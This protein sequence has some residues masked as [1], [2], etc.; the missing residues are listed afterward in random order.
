MKTYRMIQIEILKTENE[1]YRLKNRLS[2]LPGSE[3]IKIVE[4]KMEINPLTTLE[5]AAL[6]LAEELT[7]RD[8]PMTHHNIEEVFKASGYPYTADTIELA[9]P[10]SIEAC[11]EE[12]ARYADVQDFGGIN[13]E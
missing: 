11:H 4:T 3:F 13:Y 5:D 7:E 1:I 12:E 2:N 6:A 8:W 9:R 10:D